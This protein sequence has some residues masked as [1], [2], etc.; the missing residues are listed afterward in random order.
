MINCID[1]TQL[2]TF[3]VIS[4]SGLI[5]GIAAY[6]LDKLGDTTKHHP[7][8]L[9]VRGYLAIGI[10]AAFAIPLFLHTASSQLLE[11]APK[12]PELYFVLAGFCIV[13]AIFSRRFLQVVG[14]QALKIAE[15][16][17]RTAER[18]ELVAEKA[19]IEI[20]RTR[21]IISP[22]TK[23]E[24]N[25][26]DSAIAELETITKDDSGNSEAFAWLAYAYKRSNPPELQK[27]QIAMQR[28]LD[29]TEKKPPL[30]I[31]NLACYKALRGEPAKDVVSLLR[32]I[33]RIATNEERAIL[34]HDLQRD[35]DFASLFASKDPVFDEFFSSL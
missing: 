32:E 31:Y 28:A 16:A 21:K 8:V 11:E 18:T 17:E 2:P 25:A 35:E 24:N 1:F 29:L 14:Y 9:R 34:K 33:L 3:L 19:N 23:I 27:A 6:H 15:R 10:A 22:V 13:A 5:G 12:K 4:I 7:Q 20:V 26:F 30:W